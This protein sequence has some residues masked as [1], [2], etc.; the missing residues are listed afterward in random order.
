MKFIFFAA[1]LAVLFFMPFHTSNAYLHTEAYDY[2]TIQQGDS[3]WSIAGRYADDKNDIRELIAAIH[4]L[5]HIKKSDSI[6]PGQTLKIPVLYV[7]S[8]WR[9][10]F[11][12][13]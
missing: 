2:V 8:T 5:N 6:Y 7:K 13:S 11:L 3:L 4:E 10:P 1:M 12:F 9:I